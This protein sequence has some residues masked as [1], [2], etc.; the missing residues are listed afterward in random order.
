MYIPKII[1]KERRGFAQR[2]RLDRALP[3]GNR[4]RG[5]EVL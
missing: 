5:Y 4:K 2:R 3:V 1:G